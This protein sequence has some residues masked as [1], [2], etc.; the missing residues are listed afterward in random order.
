[1][2]G[3]G[4]CPEPNMKTTSSSPKSPRRPAVRTSIS[5]SARAKEEGDHLVEREG[6]QS[7][8]DLIEFLIRSR[9]END[10]SPLKA[11]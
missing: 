9:V 1:M 5:L 10:R 6:F 11:A 8:S 3:V 2:Q 4:I 7:F